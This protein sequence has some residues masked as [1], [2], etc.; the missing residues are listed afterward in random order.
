MKPTSLTQPLS[1]SAADFWSIFTASTC[2]VQRRRAQFFALL[3]EKRPV[4]EVLSLTRYHR[5]TAYTLMTRYH[6]LGLVGLD[7]ARHANTGAP[8]I[9]TPEEQQRLAHQLHTDFEQGIVWD[10]K[11]VQNWIQ[12]EFG[13]DVYIGR[14]YEFMR[15]AG[16]SPQRPRPQ[17]VGSD[18]AAREAFKTKS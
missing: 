7:D 17:H 6:A 1:H 9:L 13:K 15:A 14:T 3:A 4:R 11:R 5:T 10:G 12:T 2:A 8:T 18:A 16:F